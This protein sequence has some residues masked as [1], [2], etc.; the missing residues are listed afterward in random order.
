MQLAYLDPIRAVEVEVEGPEALARRIAETIP[1]RTSIFFVNRPFPLQPA[2]LKSLQVHL[3][4]E[5]LPARHDFACQ[6]DPAELTAEACE[7]LDKLSFRELEFSLDMENPNLEQIE[8]FFNLTRHYTFKL[9]LKLTGDPINTE[10]GQLARIYFFLHQNLGRYTLHHL[11]GTFDR[12]R[13]DRSFRQLAG[14]SQEVHFGRNYDARLQ[15]QFY[16]ILYEYLRRTLSPRVKTVLEISPFSDLRYYRDFNR[17]SLPWKVTLSGIPGSQL[18]LAQLQELGKTFDAVV[19]F[20]AL[21]RLRDPQRDVLLL[22]NYTRPTTEW[23]CVQYN[24]CSFPTLSQLIHSQFSNGMNESAYWP[25]LRMQ[26]RKSIEDLFHFLGIEFKWLPTRVPIED[27]RVLKAQLDPIFRSELPEAWDAFLA[28]SDVMVWTG[29]G[30][31]KLDDS[32]LEADG[33]VS[34]GFL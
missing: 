18:D 33:F 15:E 11:P 30:T 16:Q 14:L 1:A 26:S 20:Q 25:Q 23:V 10:A 13:I 32:E 29:H 31:M 21:P 9:V 8:A 2:F 5:K 22:Q 6:V 4:R 12:L 34:G 7:L 19:M 28:E 27:L 17:M 3:E 24:T